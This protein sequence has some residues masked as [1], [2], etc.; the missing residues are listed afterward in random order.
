MRRTEQAILMKR[1][2][3]KTKKLSKRRVLV[4]HF[5]GPTAWHHHYLYPGTE[6]SV[7]SLEAAD[8]RAFFG[9]IQSRLSQRA[10]ISKSP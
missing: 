3:K 4:D 8:T 6:T 1:Q 5:G 9:K 10:R 7:P 2:H